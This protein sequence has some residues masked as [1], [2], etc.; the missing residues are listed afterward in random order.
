ME[1]RVE[2]TWCFVFNYFGMSTS[3]YWRG[4]YIG[5]RLRTGLV[6]LGWVQV[7]RSRP[8]QINY[9]YCFFLLTRFRWY[10]ANYKEGLDSWDVQNIYIGLP[11]FSFQGG[12]EV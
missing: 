7:Y 4:Q 5:R 3:T 10:T 8:F 12:R 11:L 9:V 6:R 1:N 2:E